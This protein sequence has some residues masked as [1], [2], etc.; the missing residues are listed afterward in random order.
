MQTHHDYLIIGAGPAGLQLGYYL[1]KAGRDYLI[2]EAGESAGTFFKTFPRHR[3][4]I[5]I[6]K[7]YTGHDDPDLNMR[8]DWNSLLSD[9]PD[10]LFKNYSKDYFPHPDDFVRYLND[11]AACFD[12]K[13]AYGVRVV[14]ISKPDQFVVRDASG[15]TYTC[16]R[17]IIATGVTQPYVPPIPG[18]ELVERYVDVTID[19]QDFVNQRV[20][21]IGKG[22]SAFETA[23][24]LMGTAAVIHLASPHPLKL[25]WKSHHPG[26]LRAVNNN[27][28]DSYLLKSQNGM[29]DGT[30]ERIE[31]RD[32]KF[33]V[34]VSFTRAHGAAGE[35]VYDR[36]ILCAGFRFDATIFDESCRPAL[37]IGDRLP[38]QTSEWESTNI[39]DL[40]FAGTLTQMRDFKKTQS[41]FIHG[42]RYNARILHTILE[43]KYHG[44]PWPFQ[45]VKVTAEGLRD[46][47]LDRINRSSALWQQPGFLCDLIVVDQQTGQGHHYIEI[48]SDL[49]RDSDFGRHADYYKISLEYG[50]DYVDYPF[51]FDRYI[52]P[53]EA[54]L[55]PQ[56][57]PIIRRFAGPDV[58]DEHHIL[59]DL[60]GQWH[61]EHYVR[62]LEAFLQ[63]QVGREQPLE[64]A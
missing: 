6:N 27:F 11:F 9:N 51:E 48:P 10:M 7:V 17:L 42:F 29:L 46:A 52:G 33:H 50:P 4:L 5:S 63:R 57:H 41:T 40:Y 8:W 26:H 23:D 61:A 49:V 15:T 1:E 60:E 35:Y 38:F 13:V 55:N 62:P 12:L 19:P 53:A 37:A 58:V 28:L 34:A 16:R 18:V 2:L 32:G 47:I 36:V 20:L 64:V 56:L 43:Q 44:Q 59:E 45:P 25:A 22:N 31:R 21:L 24:N 39:K 30:I 3:M 54:H 14:G